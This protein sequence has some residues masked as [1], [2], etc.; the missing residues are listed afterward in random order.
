MIRFDRKTCRDILKV[1]K[2][3]NTSVF[4]HPNIGGYCVWTGSVPDQASVLPSIPLKEVPGSL[5]RLIEYGLITKRI[6]AMDNGMV[7]RITPELLHY[8]SFWWDRFSRKYI[9]G[10]ISGVF[11]S[12]VA[13]LILHFVVKLF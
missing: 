8:K 11:T 12:V 5:N 9:A 1:T 13:G 10:F 2:N 7:F 6:G 4:F 3:Y